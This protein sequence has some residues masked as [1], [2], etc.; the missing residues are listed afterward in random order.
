MNNFFA[1]DI[2]IRLAE[3]HSAFLCTI[4][5]GRFSSKTV[6]FSLNEPVIFENEPEVEEDKVPAPPKRR[7]E[8]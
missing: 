6:E 5:C 8:R 1:Q 7:N 4:Q 2:Y 3:D